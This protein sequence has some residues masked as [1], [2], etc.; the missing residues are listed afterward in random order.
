MK[1]TD[2]SK[3]TNQ[4]QQTPASK[5]SP[6]FA[7]SSLSSNFAISFDSGSERKAQENRQ[8][9]RSN[10]NHS[11]S[12]DKRKS[13]VS[14]KS[15]STESRQTPY[16]AS[17][18]SIS[19]EEKQKELISEEFIKNS[20]IEP[21]L[22][23]AAVEIIPDLEFDSITKEVTS[24]PIA[25]ALNWKYTRFTK[26]AK[27]NVLAAHFLQE[28]GDTWQVKLADGREKPYQA[29][30]GIGDRVYF[31]PVPQ[32]LREKIAN[33]WGVKPP[34][35]DESFWEWLKERPQIP[36]VVT[37]GGKK[38]LAGISAGFPT[39]AFYGCQCGAK[40]RDENGQSVPWHLI[41]ELTPY[42][43]GRDVYVGYDEDKKSSTRKT[44]RKWTKRLSIA[45]QKA[46][47][48]AHVM[49]WAPD[50][51]KGIDDLIANKGPGAFHLAFFTAKR[52]ELLEL[53]A[54]T[55]LTFERSI[56]V[57][58]RYLG[59]LEIPKTAKLIC[60]R[61]P[62]GTGKTYSLAEEAFEAHQNGQ[63]VLIIGHRVQLVREMC[64]KFGLPYVTELK[65][66][67]FGKTLG[68]GLCIDSLHYRSQAVFN[69]ADWS[70]AKVIIDE[71]E[72][73]FQ[74]LLFAKT[75]VS[76]H[77]REI[78]D[79]LHELFQGVTDPEGRGQL[80]L[81][82]ADLSDL[83][84]NYA[85]SLCAEGT[86]PW[87]LD[88][89]W[90]PE[91]GYHVTHFGHKN[92]TWWLYELI[93]D[94]RNGGRPL[95][96]TD[97]QKAD[98]KWA[99]QHLEVLFKELFPKKNIL[100]IDSETV[101][102]A[103][104]PAEG[105]TTRL[106]ELKNF[107][108]VIATPSIET[109][110]SI[111]FT[112]HFTSV[113]AKSQGVQASNSFRQGIERVRELVPRYLWIASLGFAR[114][115]GETDPNLIVR[116]TEKDFKNLINQLAAADYVIDYDDEGENPHLK[117][118]SRYVGAINAQRFHYRDYTLERLEQDG[119]TVQRVA[120]SDEQKAEIEAEM[121]DYYQKLKDIK[122]GKYW[123]IC[124]DIAGQENPS[125][126]EYAR[127]QAKKTKT[128]QE[129]NKERKG[130]LSRRYE[131]ERVTPEVVVDDDQGLYSALQLNYYLTRGRKF[132]EK[133]DGE[134]IEG[135]KK[136]NS[137][138]LFKHDVNRVTLTDK[139]NALEILGIQELIRMPED[140]QFTTEHPLIVKISETARKHAKQLSSV[141]DCRLNKKQANIALVQGLLQKIGVKM[142]A[143]KR[144]AKKKGQKRPPRAYGFPKPIFQSINHDELFDFWL[145]CANKKAYKNESGPHPQNQTTLARV[146]A[147][148][149]CSE[150]YI[151][152]EKVDHTFLYSIKHP[153]PDSVVIEVVENSHPDP[154]ENENQTHEEDL[155]NQ[156]QK[157]EGAASNVGG[158]QISPENSLDVKKVEERIMDI[159]R[160][161]QL[162]FSPEKERCEYAR[163]LWADAVREWGVGIV[164]IWESLSDGM[165]G[166]V[167]G[168]FG[169][170]SEE[171]E[172]SPVESPFW[173]RP[174]E[175]P[176]C[177]S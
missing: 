15:K 118:L 156:P 78:A 107:E 127:L 54:R 65:D 91:C 63:P 44:V 76:K 140:S 175:P 56:V 98:S 131:E 147:H 166:F 151:A 83:G 29:P 117:A 158:A 14:E 141:F 16:P 10:R 18:Q 122:D 40:N 136:N 142:P 47:A 100:L 120:L 3:A 86:K 66:S 50:Q 82:D 70:D 9:K 165:R 102:Q 22:F 111:N 34:K 92:P 46:G 32:P 160:L 11:N 26:Q 88:N 146:E 5:E 103:G 62:K 148:N 31:P 72:Q 167:A 13:P 134:K 97:A 30:K 53:E 43:K 114:G 8:E 20:A 81:S 39:L 159:E 106:E 132:V 112:G 89:E 52:H 96:L 169:R 162:G 23:E 51:G 1:R 116:D 133:R 108:I 27:P 164:Q 138:K 36:L 35:E 99:G 163:D 57:N 170:D 145:E 38:A 85:L 80:F 155:E 101:A 59:K 176:P 150:R 6:G 125:D 41:P 37:E 124:K 73:V 104:H 19:S 121:D 152:I 123:E 28:N 77:R 71:S 157:I 4:N 171:E 173:L 137:G 144:P 67:R 61:S 143:L 64:Q 130:T 7:S 68:Y 33:L 79:N 60:I 49:R 42:A 172:N 153:I 90:K 139:V 95:I 177:T 149:P 87:L 109:G 94:I 126:R 135:Q 45:L 75:N 84:V 161:S 24:A 2:T 12:T 174:P 25:E 128:R 119:H 48:K 21:K 129:R 69:P 113:W 105:I 110:V 93:E 168:W 58:N 115:S 74:H 17:T 154:R 55:Q